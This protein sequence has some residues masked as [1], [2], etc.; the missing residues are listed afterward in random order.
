MIDYKKFKIER[1]DPI[2]STFCA[3]KWA[4]SDFWLETGMTSSCHL[5]PPHKINLI[6]IQ[7]NINLLHNTKEKLN[8]KELMLQNEKPAGC[9]NCWQVEELNNESISER[10][11]SSYMY[12]NSDFNTFDLTVNHIPEKIT[13]AFDSLCNFT[14]SYCDASQS[15]SWATDLKIN[16]P[17]K[18]IFGDSRNTYQRLGSSNKLLPKEFDFISEKFIEYVSNNLTKI[19]FIRCL[20]GEPLISVNF[21]LFISKITQLDCSNIELCIITN[22]SDKNRVNKLLTYTDKFKKITIHASIENTKLHAEFIR[23]GLKW[24]N[25]E[26]NFKYLVDTNIEI[27]LIS[28]VSGLALDGLINFLDWYKPYSDR[29]SLDLFR[30]RHPNFQAIQVLPKHL[31]DIYWHNLEIWLEENKKDLAEPLVEQIK[32]IMTII[33]DDCIIYDNVNINVLQ[34]S[35]K[36]FYKQYAIRRQHQIRNVFSEEMSSWI[37][38]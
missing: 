5:P 3:T 18:K 37:L 21:W 15:S 32:N 23:S 25:F 14:C 6:D 1:L 2:S 7:E 19:K 22:L 27:T 28:T 17:Y 8:Q 31:K 35:F 20:G 16:G 12:S 11:A 26:S 13:V 10:I 38:N 33:K 4:T 34:Q 29:V 30:L 36:E 24:D 9:S